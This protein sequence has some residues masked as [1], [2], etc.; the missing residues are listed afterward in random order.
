MPIFEGHA[1]PHAIMR[2]DLAGRDITDY[3]MTLMAERGYFFL[4]QD[5]QLVEDVKEKLTFVALDFD[6]E[7]KT[8]AES[9]ASERSYELPDGNVIT[10]GNERFRCAEI[11]FQSSFIGKELPGVHDCAFQ[12]IMKCDADIQSDL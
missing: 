10:L 11:L 5:R 7:M 6:Q 3:L 12:T 1:L 8:S 2:L 4:P 9:S